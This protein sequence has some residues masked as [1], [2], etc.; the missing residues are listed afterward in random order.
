MKFKVIAFIFM[1]SFVHALQMQKVL[2]DLQQPWGM[3]WLGEDKML[4]TEKKGDVKIL[5]LKNR[6]IISVK[7]KI[8]SAEYGQG[9]LLDVALDSDFK[10]TQRVFF[11]ATKAVGDLYTTALFSAKLVEKK[12]L[13]YE[14]KEVR[15][16]FVALPAGDD[17]VHF[18]SRLVVTN[19]EVW[20]TV[21]DRGQRNLAQD[22]KTHM[23]KVLRLDKN[24]KAM[25]DNP[26]V[27]RADAKPEIWSYGHRNPQ[28]FV[29]DP[30]TGEF[31]VHEHGPKG[32]DEINIL[33]KGA[34]YGWPVVTFGREYSGEKITNET[35]RPD[36]E[37]PVHYYVP[38]IAPCGMILYQ[39]DKFPELKDSFLI[40]SLVLTHL[41]QVK[42]E[43]KKFIFEKRFFENQSLRIRDV[44]AT[45]SG[46]VYFFTDSGD[47]YQLLNN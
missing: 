29:R 17:G 6:K 45:P 28:G 34:N 44:E 10:N 8:P 1:S 16:L 27:G 7:N 5:D 30:Q 14:L 33:K 13:Q 26:F 15:E 32:G 2:S 36:I 11:T 31:W 3:A 40:G 47:L 46:D 21:G 19:D 18:G 25:T 37:S 9:G 24:G 12:S 38:S 22:L 43:N 4:M 23:G 41:N 35:S 20:M 39:G 42:I